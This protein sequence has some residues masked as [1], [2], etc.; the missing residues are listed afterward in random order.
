LEVYV[1]A[2]DESL[3]WDRPD[4][5]RYECE[6]SVP[7]MPGG[8]SDEPLDLSNV[9][10][11]DKTPA[12]PSFTSVKPPASQASGQ[13]SVGGLHDNLDLLGYV[14]MTYRQNKDAIQ[15]WQG[16]A[17]IESRYTGEKMAMGHDYSATAQFVFDRARKSLCWN[18]TLNRWT[19]SREGREEPQPA[20]QISNGMVTPDAFYR[21]GSGSSGW[22]ANPA[23]R[24]LTLTIAAS[25]DPRSERLQP[26]LYDFNPLYYLDTFRGDVARDLSFYIGAADHPGLANTKVIREGD[27]V[28]IDMGTKES[29]N[30]YTL[31][32]SHGCN[33]VSCSGV[34][35]GMTSE[36]RW[37]YE[38][39]DGIWLPKTWMET[40]HQKGVRDEQRNV[41]FVEN[42]VNQPVEPAAFSLP[43]LGVE[44]G[45]KVQDRRTQPVTQYQYEGE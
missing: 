26:Q 25:G 18:T 7:E 29:Y 19:Q 3:P 1:K 40:V 42:R 22:P 16:K 44:R 41:T 23:K 6:F 43:R 14:A 32:L 12:K 27:L 33:P 37:T 13:K 15:T 38:K 17:S 34:S 36:W 9:L 31:S 45:D 4:M 24:P 11:A 35:P 5:L 21:V 30:R 28:T 10:L 8:V 39:V 20:P 2:N